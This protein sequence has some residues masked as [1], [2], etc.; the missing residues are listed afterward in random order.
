MQYT[1][2]R[3]THTIDATGQVLGR[4]ATRIAF[5]LMGK[6]KRTYAPNRD[7]G[8]AV[9]VTNLSNIRLSGHKRVEKEYKR[10]S[11]YP[12]GLKRV[13]AQTL[14][15]TNPK[16]VL[17]AAVYRMLPKNRLRKEMIKRLKIEP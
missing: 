5:L 14:L 13:R 6:H 17:W 1:V 10:F 7:T 9:V 8:D 16:K 3:T 15:G 11:G 4:L 12:G 2:D